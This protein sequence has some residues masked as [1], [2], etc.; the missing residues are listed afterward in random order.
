MKENC[1]LVSDY[2]HLH[3]L[4]L[5][6]FAHNRKVLPQLIADINNLKVGENISLKPVVFFI[7]LV[8][9]IEY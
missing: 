3:H 6:K 1:L 9:I 2:K 4:R 5:R 7:F 8:H